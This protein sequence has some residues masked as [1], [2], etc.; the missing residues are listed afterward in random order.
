MTTLDQVIDGF[1]ENLLGVEKLINFDREILELMIMQLTDLQSRLTS[2]GYDNPRLN[3][4]TTLQL[5]ARVRE[6]DSLRPR[7]RTIFNQAVVLLVS[8]FASALGD[9]FRYGISARLETEDTGALFDEEIKLTILE[10]KDR[11]WNLKEAVPDLLIAK[12]DFTF[13]D[14]GATHRA[15]QT[16]L[17]VDIERGRRVNNII[18]AQACRHVIVHAGGKISERLLRQVASA[19][20]RDLKLSLEAGTLVQFEPEEVMCVAEE[21]RLYIE[22]LGAQV[23]E[24]LHAARQPSA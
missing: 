23:E 8:Y 12:K 13:Q 21:M 24:K 7:Y 4:A 14:M 2:Q 15:F 17:G 6:N 3:V 16:Y 22:S 9:V 5:I 20:P 11:E 10:L 19:S 1:R 18:L